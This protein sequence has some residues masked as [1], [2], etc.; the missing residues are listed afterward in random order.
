MNSSISADELV[1]R[2][3]EFS[4]DRL[5]VPWTSGPPYVLPPEVDL[6]RTLQ[7]TF[8]RDRVAGGVERIN[9]RVFSDDELRSTSTRV[10]WASA[11]MSDF[12]R[13]MQI[14]GTT[15][16]NHMGDVM[17]SMTSI[18]NK[19]LLHSNSP[20]YAREFLAASIPAERG[21]E[22]LSP[23]SL[24]SFEADVIRFRPHLVCL[25]GLNVNTRILLRMAL[26]ARRHGVQELWIGAEAAI[27]PYKIID[28]VFDRAFFGLGEQYFYEK[29]VGDDFP[30][31]IHPRAERMLADVHWFDVDPNDQLRRVEFNTLHLAFRLGC[32]QTCVYCAERQKS[33]GIRPTTAQ[34]TLFEI[35]DDAADM[36]I[37]RA[38]FVDPDFG[39]LWDDDLVAVVRHLHRR[40]MRWSCLTNIRTLHDHGDFLIEHGLSSVY[41][42][43]ES[44]APTHVGKRGNATLQLLNRGWQ[45]QDVT[46]RL[47]VDLAR[48]GVFVIGLYILANP[49]ESLEASRAGV[50]RLLTLP[51]PISQFS[52]NQPFPGTQE[53][54]ASANKGWIHN[55]D[56]DYV[57]Y[58]RSVWAPDGTPLPPADVEAL[59]VETHKRFNDLRRPGGFVDH[60]KSKQRARARP[61]PASTLLVEAK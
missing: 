11:P 45:D 19:D 27:G 17:G 10:L 9:R 14:G 6:E 8:A 61:A 2:L 36:G 54:A 44:L 57:I 26:I 41:L 43:I 30:G 21:V 56:P 50:D 60:I 34:Q 52:T 46:A 22:F 58:G 24:E 28:E 25:S 38:Y 18:A 5:S 39:R 29:F 42:G 23:Q 32:T 37:R 13:V 49:G 48:K 35:I 40:G 55:Y 1:Q 3:E 12:R 53:F 47:I 20:N 59:F 15:V 51:V 33:G 16:E 7:F 31:V 4:I